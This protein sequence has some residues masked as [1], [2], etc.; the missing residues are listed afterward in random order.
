MASISTD[1][2]GLR[3]ILVT[4]PNS[5]AGKR[6]CVRSVPKDTEMNYSASCKT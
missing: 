3:R 2:A 6:G 1:S 5:A 4:K